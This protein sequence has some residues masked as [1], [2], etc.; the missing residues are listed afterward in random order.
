MQNPA[1]SAAD[2]GIRT[3]P[4]T[5]KRK[6]FSKPAV[7]IA[8]LDSASCGMLRDTGDGAHVL[9]TWCGTKIRSW[10]SAVLEHVNT[11]SHKGRKP[12]SGRLDSFV[13]PPTTPTRTPAE[14]SLLTTK[15]DFLTHLAL[16]LVACDVPFPSGTIPSQVLS[17]P[18]ISLAQKLLSPSFIGALLQG[19]SN[20]VQV[21]SSS[22]ITTLSIIPVTPRPP[23]SH[24]ALRPLIS[25]ACLVSPYCLAVLYC[26]IVHT[27]ISVRLRL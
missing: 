20:L 22:H 4:S 15:V 8:G 6:H 14:L 17:C 12:I 11:D 5:K 13:A 21:H 10:R 23:P 26:R 16:H 18:N 9:C 1:V 2:V 24:L 27:H 3:P 19:R 7:V 25:D